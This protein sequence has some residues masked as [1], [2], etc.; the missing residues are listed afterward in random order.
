M[1]PATLAS[2]AQR[3]RIPPAWSRRWTQLREQADSRWRQL[4]TR[5]QRLV[6]VM[7]AL[8]AIALLIQLA[9]R[10][11]WRDIDAAATELPRLR[12]QAAQVDAVIQEA[13]ALQGA[14]RGRIAPEA[15]EGELKASL[16]SAG[17]DGEHTIEPVS[18]SRE[19]AWDLSFQQSAAAPLLNWLSTMPSQLRLSVQTAEVNRATDA[20]GKPVPARVSGSLR[21]VAGEDPQ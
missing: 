11:A 4:S 18:G 17:V 20:N 6:L 9:V 14:V 19:P 15:M 8:V 13:L 2:T 10:P 3:L 12:A 21:L 16:S 5:E 1:K 7:A